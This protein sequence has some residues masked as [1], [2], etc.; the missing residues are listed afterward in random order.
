MPISCP[1]HEL[2]VLC[3]KEPVNCSQ[4][5]DSLNAIT[6]A[7][8]SHGIPYSSNTSATIFHEHHVKLAPLQQLLQSLGCPSIPTAPPPQQHIHAR[9]AKPRLHRRSP[10]LD[11]PATCTMQ[12]VLQDDCTWLAPEY[13]ASIDTLVLTFGEEPLSA[14][15]LSNASAQ[16]AFAQV[17]HAV[18][19]LTLSGFVTAQGMDWVLSPGLWA[20]V[21]VLTIEGYQG[22][23]FDFAK[24]NT[25][26]SHLAHVHIQH[27][28]AVHTMSFD[29]DHAAGIRTINVTNCSLADL[30]PKLLTLYPRLETLV[31]SHN[32]IRQWDVAVGNGDEDA[33]RTTDTAPPTATSSTGTDAAH[34]QLR[35]LYLDYNALTVLRPEVLGAL[36]NLRVLRVAH[37]G[38][39]TLQRGT[40]DLVPQLQ[41]LDLS[42]TA[43][44]E[45]DRDIFMHLRHLKHLSIT[46]TSL[47]ALPPGLFRGNTALV[48]LR[49]NSNVLRDVPAGVFDGLSSLVTLHL[50]RNEIQT[51]PRGLLRDLVALEVA[52]LG[53]NE[54]Q[55]VDASLFASC[56]GLQDVRLPANWLSRLPPNLFPHAPNLTHVLL[57]DNR[58]RSVDG[59]FDNASALERLELDSNAITAFDAH[60]PNLRVLFMRNNPLRSFPAMHGLPMLRELRLKDHRIPHIPL[61]A[62][63]AASQHLH[64]LQLDARASAHSVIVSD[65]GGSGRR[66][67]G[68]EMPPRHLKLLSLINVDAGVLF[69]FGL[70]RVATRVRQLHLGWPTMGE[71]TAPLGDICHALAARVQDLTLTTTRYETIELCPDKQFVSLFLQDNAYLTSVRT[72][73]ALRTLNVSGC[74]QLAS[75]DVPFAADLDISRTKVP[76]S[77]SICERLGTRILFARGMAAPDLYRGAETTATLRR[78]MERAAIVDISDNAWVDD[79]RRMA[80]AAGGFVALSAK[81]LRN[82][83]LGYVTTRETPP[84]LQLLNTPVQCE[85][86]L[87][88]QDLQQREKFNAFF[89]KV[90]YV[91][92]CWCA[93][94]FSFSW[95]RDKCTP[96]QL[97]GPPVATIAAGSVFGGLALG[98]A[99]AW[100]Y[101][102]Y[103]R[104][105]TRVDLQQQ[106]LHE[107]DEEVLALRSVWEIQHEELVFRERVAAGGYGV[108]YCAEWD[109]VTVA[110][111]LLQH[112]VLSLDEDTVQVFEK[113]IEFLQRTRHPHVVRFFGAG[114][115]PRGSPFLV[116]EYVALGSLRDLLQQDLADVLNGSGVGAG[117]GGGRGAGRGGQ[118]K[119]REGSMPAELH[120]RTG[121]FDDAD[122]CGD[123]DTVVFVA[124]FGDTTALLTTEERQIDGVTTVWALKLQLLRDI[125]SGMAFIHSLD[126]M[127]R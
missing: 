53:F 64:L 58:L 47:M 33:A 91:F 7:F 123:D 101:H 68:R 84:V 42:F 10:K 126:Q 93:P 19:H 114:T 65:A 90:V 35:Q 118:R 92:Q 72:S 28:P 62:A 38:I 44:E 61:Q 95:S 14:S 26:T 8:D 89:T 102:R 94:G 109:G 30:P 45:L 111:K 100:I 81:A 115:D 78:C 9:L 119:E 80:V 74:P 108:V 77:A 24:L 69:A 41:D 113:E 29:F 51:L 116:L 59:V 76:L 20:S 25:L 3:L 63:L 4:L 85:L 67:E 6:S 16:D 96:V 40:F 2:F 66:G 103:Q 120:T 98:L 121:T 70:Q 110:V 54:L 27:S 106:L 75:I 21:Q 34:A 86:Q 22:N 23:V 112:T 12:A 17:T 50:H 1:P 31:A 79:P 73:S 71:E 5:T 124:G 48:S 18:T 56:H 52:F 104:L 39:A 46:D 117:A 49:L 36:P 57:S 13:T 60:L 105:A 11:K 99:V 97:P 32:R 125:A 83:A 82:P 55:Q 107:R 15:R 127:H 122:D 43:L 87:S 37:N 88:N